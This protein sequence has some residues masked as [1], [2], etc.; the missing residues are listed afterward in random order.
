MDI[1][2]TAQLFRSKAYGAQPDKLSAG[3]YGSD[4][5]TD[6]NSHTGHWGV[7]KANTDL[8]I[9]SITTTNVG[10]A[11]MAGMN[12]ARGDSYFC[13]FTQLTLTSGKAWLYRFG[14]Q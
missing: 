6:T 10:G 7:I 5:I 13:D 12:I 14:V 8:V 11:S 4:F 3:M 1:S 2:S 9:G